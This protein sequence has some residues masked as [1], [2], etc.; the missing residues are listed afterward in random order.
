M[1]N[2]FETVILNKWKKNPIIIQ[3]NLAIDLFH[4]SLCSLE[5]HLRQNELHV[6]DGSMTIGDVDW[7]GKCR[8]FDIVWRCVDNQNCQ[9]TKNAVIGNSNETQVKHSSF[10]FSCITHTHNLIVRKPFSSQR[11]VSPEKTIIIVVVVVVVVSDLVMVVSCF[12]SFVSL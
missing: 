3:L 10:M 1:I 9:C 2:N 11:C 8:Q 4:W 5:S 7:R 6:A 12:H